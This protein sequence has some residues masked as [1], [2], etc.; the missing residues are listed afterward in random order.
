[1][2]INKQSFAKKFA[3]NG[4][5]TVWEEAQYKLG[6]ETVGIRP[7]TKEQFN[8]LFYNI[9]EKLS[10][11]SD[12]LDR[13][14]E[15]AAGKGLP[16]GAVIGF[17]RAITSQEGFLKADGSTFAQATYPDLHRVLGSN[18]LPNLTR[19][20]I[21][22]TAYF[23]FDDIPDGWI[24]YDEIAAKVTQSAYPE[25]YRKLVAQYG[26]IDAVP[27]A[28]DRFIRNVSG[29][30]MV[31]AV[32]EDM[33][34][35][36]IHGIGLMSGADDALFIR[37][38]W[39]E[40]TLNQYNVIQINGQL[41]RF[42]EYDISPLSPN[43]AFPHYLATAEDERSNQNG[44][45]RPK[46]IAM[47]LCIKAKDSLDDVVMWVKA[48]GKVTNAGVLDASTLAAGLQNKSDKGH[49]HT[50]AEITDF[51]TAVEAVVSRL[52]TSEKSTS[53]YLKF[54]GGLIFEWGLTNQIS[55]SYRAITF[56]IAFPNA[57]LNV[58]ATPYRDAVVGGN[59]VISAHVGS[60]SR[61]GCAIGYSENLGDAS[62][63]V[64]WIAIGF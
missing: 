19:S 41:N 8:Y 44:E 55:E 43:G 26:S 58:M 1:M 31:G 42:Q 50:A 38:R 20:D 54:A 49:T 6:W 7:P 25:L 45:T 13:K 37:K 48:F 53:G 22:M 51:D 18:K 60:I 14:T 10:F 64:F 21:G 34:A 40:H 24:K 4:Q 62:R 17:P 9:D 56:P 23:P 12:E 57:C 39:G 59:G 16:V 52:F 5:R 47:V 46:A 36:H 28:D 32:Q 11:L 33:T 15:D 29:S 3:E 27:K 2:A 30:L 61:T 35:E 63:G